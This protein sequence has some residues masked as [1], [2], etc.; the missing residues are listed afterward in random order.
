LEGRTYSPKN[1]NEAIENW[2]EYASDNEAEYDEN[3]NINISNKLPMVTWGTNPEQGIEII[4]NIP[5]FESFSDSAKRRAAEKALDYNKLKPNTPIANTPI[6]FVFIGSCTNA[7]I[8]DMRE[9]AK[10]LKNNKIADN[11]KVYIVN[12]SEAVRA[13]CIEEGLDKVFTDFGADFRMSGC[14]MCLAMN[15]DF[16]PVGERCAS[17]SNRNFVGR[18]GAGSFTHLMSPMM[19]AIVAIT[20]KITNPEDFFNK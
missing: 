5:S 19:A 13:Q 20:G 7:R 3:I 1:F 18:Q 16:V 9:A 10:I 17:T 6:D 12:G 8:E 14:S 11:I 2:Q 4:E 15:G